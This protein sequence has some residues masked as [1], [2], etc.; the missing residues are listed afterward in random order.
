MLP[1]VCNAYE[2]AASQ[3]IAAESLPVLIVQEIR[4]IYTDLP[5][6]G[7]VIIADHINSRVRL[8]ITLKGPDTPPKIIDPAE[9]EGCIPSLLPVA[10]TNSELVLGRVRQQYSV[11][12]GRGVADFEVKP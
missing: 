9:C 12:A 11:Q 4:D 5:V 1:T 3:Q 7:Q 8:Y 10:Q 2:S 6:I